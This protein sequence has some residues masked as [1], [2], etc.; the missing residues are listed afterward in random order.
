MNFGLKTCKT[1]YTV[2]DI[3]AQKDI[4]ILKIQ[5]SILQSDTEELDTKL[6][7]YEFPE[8]PKV[9]IDLTDVNHICSTALGILVSYKK[10][11]KDAQGD[12]MVVIN[13]EDLLQL[14]EI[15][16]LDK[17]F[18]ICPT[19]EDAKDEFRLDS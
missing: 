16:M 15:T 13:D 11:F 4:H 2:M 1:D 10:R 14:F 7:T 6:S 17:V 5:G 12:I 3:T 18:T 9:I 8:S 19:V